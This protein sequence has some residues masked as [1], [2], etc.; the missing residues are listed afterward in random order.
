LAWEKR[1]LETAFLDPSKSVEREA[2]FPRLA[3]SSRIKE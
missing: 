2:G 3:A 1:A